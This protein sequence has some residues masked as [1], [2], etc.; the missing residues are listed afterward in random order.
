MVREL[1][2]ESKSSDNLT[3]VIFDI[4]EKHKGKREWLRYI[5]RRLGF[6][7]AQK[8]VF[9]GKVNIP[10][11]FLVDLGKMGLIGF[12]EIFEVSKEGSLKKL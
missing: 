8:S 6:E 2:Y 5:L 9:M 12:V 7:M 10:Q 4:P 11:R 3:I 1:D